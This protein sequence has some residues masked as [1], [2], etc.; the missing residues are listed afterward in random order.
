MNLFC[1]TITNRPNAGNYVATYNINSTVKYQYV[2]LLV[3]QCYATSSVEI[4]MN[5]SYGNNLTESMTGPSLSSPV[6]TGDLWLNL[7][8][9]LNTPK[10]WNGTSW[11]VTQFV[12]LGEF[13]RTSGVIGTVTN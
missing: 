13:V 4:W 8:V 3:T 12:R 7:S 11:V 2:R 5:I 10:K 6:C 1:D 9:S